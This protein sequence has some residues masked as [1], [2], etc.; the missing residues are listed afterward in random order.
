MSK[1]ARVVLA[2]VV[3][4][5]LSAY[6]E[7]APKSAVFGYFCVEV[8]RS[9]RIRERLIRALVQENNQYVSG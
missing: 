9:T 6:A 2:L 5:S 8:K 7:R 3:C 1:I 4:M